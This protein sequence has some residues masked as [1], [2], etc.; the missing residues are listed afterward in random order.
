MNNI[1]LMSGLEYI[2]MLAPI[3]MGII[4]WVLMSKLD[5]VETALSK[6]TSQ[7]IALQRMMNTASTMVHG[8]IIYIEQIELEHQGNW[9]YDYTKLH[10]IKSPVKLNHQELL[11]KINNLDLAIAADIDG[12]YE[13][14]YEILEWRYEY[15]LLDWRYEHVSL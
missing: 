14:G 4:I 1:I 12:V 5:E 2:W 15:V 9:S 7:H 11:D 6:M 8:Y 10:L 3:I 13:D